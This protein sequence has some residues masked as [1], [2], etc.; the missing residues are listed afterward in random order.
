MHSHSVGVV[1]TYAGTWGNAGFTNGQ[2]TFAR[3]NCPTG[4]RQ[5]SSGNLFLGDFSNHLIRKIDRLVLIFY[6]GI[7]AIIL[8]YEIVLDIMFHQSIIELP[9]YD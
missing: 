1:S 5:D 4:M 9:I 7:Q 3:F 8:Y 2:G 6:D